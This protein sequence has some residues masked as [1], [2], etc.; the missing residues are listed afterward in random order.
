MWVQRH[1]LTFGGD[2]TKVTVYG[3]GGSVT[4]Q[5]I[6]YGEVS[7]PPFGAAV[8]KHPWWQSYSNDSLLEIQY[9][10]QL[11]ATN[12]TNLACLRSLPEDTLAT[13]SQ[14]TYTKVYV[15]SLYKYGSFY[16]GPSI[17]GDNNTRPSFQR[18]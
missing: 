12:C 7:N 15:D 6:M 2:P 5:M 14:T 11:S 18:I 16:Y 3:G 4:G 10:G 8:A 1:I 9:S 17:D 13:A